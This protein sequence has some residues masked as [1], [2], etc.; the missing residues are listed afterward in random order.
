VTTRLTLYNDA[1]LLVGE[2]FLSSLTE[3]R[4][5]RRLLDQ[6]WSSGAINYCLEQGQWF[7]AM[8]TIQIDYDPSIEPT[9]GYNRAFQKPTDWVL[10]SSF[11]SDEFF[12]CPLTRYVDEAGY[13]YAEL[14]TV[15]VRYVSNDTGYGMD[16]NKWPDSFREFVAAH[17]ASRIILKLSNSESKEKELKDMR[18]ALLKNAKSRCAMADPTQFSAQGN[19]SKSRMRGGSRRGDGGNGNTSGNL[20]G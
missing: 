7:F 14:D 11:A 4:E 10:T 17:I 8:R 5:P 20:I 9:F 1:L 16:M 6:V 3:E 18:K 13:W 12:R 19:W 2:R 15:Y